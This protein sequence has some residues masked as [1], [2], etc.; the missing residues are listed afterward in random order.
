MPLGVTL[1]F[2]LLPLCTTCFQWFPWISH[3]PL[4]AFDSVSL[5]VL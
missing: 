4:D 5:V 3:L 2:G 1:M